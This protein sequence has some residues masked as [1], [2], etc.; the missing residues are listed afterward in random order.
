MEGKKW[1]TILP[2]PKVHKI[3]DLQS[4]ME[5][6]LKTFDS[7]IDEYYLSC[8]PP[9]FKERKDLPFQTINILSIYKKYLSQLKRIK[10]FQLAYKLIDIKLHLSYLKTTTSYFYRGTTLIVGDNNLEKLNPNTISLLRENHYRVFL[11]SILIEEILDLLQ[12][13]F[14]DELGDFKRNKWEKLVEKI[15]V[16]FKFEEKEEEMINKLKEYRTAEFHKYSKVR[17]FLSK[18]KWDHFQEEEKTIEE[19]LGRLNQNTDLR[20]L[21]GPTG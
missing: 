19:L 6:V 20:G 16:K 2:T 21:L 10:G 18:E 4:N 1:M 14:F 13:I 3:R 7:K 12:I 9:I 15:N 5:D 11:I 17:G 8:L